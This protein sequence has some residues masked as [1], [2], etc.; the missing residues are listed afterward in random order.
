[1]FVDNFCFLFRRPYP[2]LLSFLH[3]FHLQLYFSIKKVD[4]MVVF[5]VSTFILQLHY[6]GGTTYACKAVCDWQRLKAH[7]ANDDCK[8]TI[9]PYSFRSVH[10][11][12]SASRMLSQHKPLA[13]TF[14]IIYTCPCAVFLSL[15][16]YSTRK[17]FQNSPAQWYVPRILDTSIYDLGVMT[18]RSTGG[19]NKP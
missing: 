18:T 2:F 3:Y 1:M 8:Q 10:A 17:L 13:K 14:F 4:I 6:A 11:L 9:F 5:H 7:I 15:H 16:F 12:T 19:M